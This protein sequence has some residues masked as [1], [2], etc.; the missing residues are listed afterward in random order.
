M[1]AKADAVLLSLVLLHIP[2][3]AAMLEKL[4]A[5]LQPGG[6]LYLVDFLKNPAVS[7]PLVHNGFDPAA[8]TQLAE[9]T[10][11]AVTSF[12]V[13]HEADHLFMNQPAAMFLAILKKPTE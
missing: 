12:T 8:L 13:F 3:T 9:T 2:D 6:T 1:Q 11:F 4:Y 7:H 5:L 10:G